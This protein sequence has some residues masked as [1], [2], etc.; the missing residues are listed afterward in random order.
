MIG[1]IRQWCSK[2]TVLDV[3]RLS[4]LRKADF[5]SAQGGSTLRVSLLGI[6]RHQCRVPRCFRLVVPSELRESV[7]API[8]GEVTSGKG[9]AQLTFPLVNGGGL[10]LSVSAYCT[11]GGHSLIGE[12]IQ[13]D[14]ELSLDDSGTDN[15]LQ[16]AI[17]LLLK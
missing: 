11:G 16:A 3:R 6:T 17:D 1:L 7:Q 5:R 2:N 8:V 15:Q 12:G 13:P 4:W 9:Y 10:G 14:V